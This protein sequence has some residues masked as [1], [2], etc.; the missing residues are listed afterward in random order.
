MNCCS[1][2]SNVTLYLVLLFVIMVLM[3]LTFAKDICLP[4]VHGICDGDT[5]RCYAGYGGELC[6]ECIT[7][8]FC[9]HGYCIN[10][11]G[12]K[13][14]PGWRGMFCDID[15]KGYCNYHTP[16]KNGGTC[17]SLG[18]D[19]F[20]CNCAEDFSGITCQNW[21]KGPCSCKNNGTCVKSR[22][23]RGCL[24]PI[25]YYGEHCESYIDRCATNPCPANSTCVHTAVGY[26]CDCKQ[27]QCEKSLMVCTESTCKQGLLC[28]KKPGQFGYTCHCQ[29]GTAGRGCL[30]RPLCIANTCM[31]GGKCFET[32]ENVMCVCKEGYTGMQ[33]ETKLEKCEYNPCA[34]NGTCIVSIHGH[35]CQCSI[36]YAGKYCDCIKTADENCGLEDPKSSSCTL[37]NL[38]NWN[39]RIFTIF[40]VIYIYL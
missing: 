21:L 20:T 10:P 5:C 30:M 4:C 26:R 18:R 14:K 17:S 23:G 16:C 3:A 32:L 25:N 15:S 22:S 9:V 29:R 33:C 13:C 19:G 37:K 27:D 12:C 2:Q 8:G 11:G 35:S 6:D 34:N 38:N 31:N 24:C 7:H 1:T 39:Q 36:G 40:L 28:S